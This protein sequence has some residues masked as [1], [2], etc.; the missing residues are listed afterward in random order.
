[1][2]SSSEEEE[3]SSSEEEETPRVR[4]VP[5]EH[6]APQDGGGSRDA[7]SRIEGDLGFQTWYWRHDGTMEDLE[8]VWR[9]LG[10]TEERM[11]IS[12]TFSYVLRHA[13]RSLEV[14][15]RR[16]GFARFDDILKLQLFHPYSMKELVA[17]SLF[18]C[19]VMAHC[20]CYDCSSCIVLRIR[21]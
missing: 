14:R 9:R 2:D 21:H 4:F 3:D 13:A 19:Y 15:I 18:F 8:P 20:V 7:S 1:M 10:Q 16:D 17:V 6:G 11:K 12:K 5:K